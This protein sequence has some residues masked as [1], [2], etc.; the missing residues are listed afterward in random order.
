MIEKNNNSKLIDFG[1]SRVLINNDSSKKITIV[2]NGKMIGKYHYSPPE[3]INGHY[4]SINQTSDIYAAGITFYEL[5]SGVL[6]FNNPN[7]NELMRMQI[8]DAIPP[9]PMIP[10]QLF[11]IIKKATAKEQSKRFQSAEEFNSAI[12]NSKKSW[13]SW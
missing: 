9:N 8:N 11:K 2:N 12:V 3:Q 6:P 1:I 4:E 7:V 13:F 5:L 10:K